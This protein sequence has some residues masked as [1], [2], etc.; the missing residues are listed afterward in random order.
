MKLIQRRLLSAA[1]CSETK[2][3]TPKIRGKVE[4][5]DNQKQNKKSI[6]EKEET[7]RISTFFLLKALL[8]ALLNCFGLD[9]DSLGEKERGVAGLGASTLAASD[10]SPLKKA[11]ME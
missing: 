11:E 3:Q 2:N 9:S 1:H 7:K 6:E 10:F 4:G 8:L 5:K